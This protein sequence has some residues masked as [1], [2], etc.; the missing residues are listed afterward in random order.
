MMELYVKFAWHV[1]EVKARLRSQKGQG[2]VEYGL[3][4]VLVSIA[5]IGALLALNTQL[6]TVFNNIVNGLQGSNP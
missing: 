2:M 5:V 1:E 6:K 4:L 3:I